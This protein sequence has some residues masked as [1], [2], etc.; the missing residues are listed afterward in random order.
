MQ[1]LTADN[2]RGIRIRTRIAIICALLFIVID[3]LFV[4][5]NYRYI[6]FTVP[7]FHDVNG[8]EVVARHKSAFFQYELER[9]LFFIFIAVVAWVIKPLFKPPILHARTRCL[10]FALANLFICT[11]IG[12][13]MIELAIAKGDETVEI[14]YI[15]Q[16]IVLL[17]WAIVLWIEY[18]MD[19][20]KIRKSQE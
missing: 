4:T 13:S 3:I 20:K 14:S 19:L 18:R 15:W 2:P 8:L 11:G 9:I 6:P 12:I 1:S 17:F 5:F 16:Y 10:L 7:G